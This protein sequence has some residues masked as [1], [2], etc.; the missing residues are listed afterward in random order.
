MTQSTYQTGYAEFEALSERLITEHW[1]FYPT[2]GSRIGRHEYDGRLPELSPSQVSRRVQ[3]LR[4]GLAEVRRLDST[5]LGPDAQLSQK[6]L[7]L[8]LQREIFTFEEMRP[9]EN[10][11]M[12]QAGFLNMGGYVRRD[13]AP[14]EDRLRSATTAL[15]LVPEF[16]QTIDS[17]L[18]DDL[19]RHIVDMSVESYSGMAHFYR[20]DLASFASDVQDQEASDPFLEAIGSAAVAIDA[21]VE[22]L[23]ERSRAD[24][25]AFAIGSRL[26]SRMLATGE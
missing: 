24:D 12:R 23:K 21:F 26:Y 15:R 14:L 9:L 18:R 5:S 20:T 1:D 17:W 8:F 3:E 13:Y 2:T 11:P 22:R 7:D 25:N 4:R 6:M 19:S 10:N 16:L